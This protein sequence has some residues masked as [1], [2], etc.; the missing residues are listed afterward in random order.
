MGNDP[1]P[2]LFA[3]KKAQV[4]WTFKGCSKIKSGIMNI[5]DEYYEFNILEV[6]MHSSTLEKEFRLVILPKVY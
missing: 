2:C 3:P 5:G 1:M 6:E 4:L